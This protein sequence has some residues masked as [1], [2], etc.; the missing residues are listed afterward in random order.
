MRSTV[1]LL[2]DLL[3]RARSN[4]ALSGISLREFFVEAVEMRLQKGR[5]KRTGS[6]TRHW[7]TWTAGR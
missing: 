6:A 7:G 2:D 5:T 4:A 3:Q 1:E